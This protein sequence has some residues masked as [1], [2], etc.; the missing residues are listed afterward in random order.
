MNIRPLLAFLVVAACATPPEVPVR[1]TS[2]SDA[3]YPALVP[4]DPILAAAGAV[5]GDD[6]AAGLDARAAALNARAGA[7]RG[8]MD[9]VPAVPALQ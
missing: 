6:P 5:P 1:L 2:D 3:P 7:L 9:S 4:L 8:P